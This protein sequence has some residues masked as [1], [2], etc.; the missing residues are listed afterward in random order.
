MGKCREE[1]CGKHWQLSHTGAERNQK[2]IWIS[3]RKP[4]LPF[5]SLHPPEVRVGRL[6]EVVGPSEPASSIHISKEAKPSPSRRE[7][8]MYLI[9]SPEDAC[10]LMLI[11]MHACEHGETLR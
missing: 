5:T 11:N 3:E 1:S 4:R 7:K 9:R 6:W 10:S 2:R 8:A